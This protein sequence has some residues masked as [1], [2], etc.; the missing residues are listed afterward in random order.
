MLVIIVA[1]NLALSI[2]LTGVRCFHLAG[3]EKRN[4][5][6]NCRKIVCEITIGKIDNY[7]K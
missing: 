1:V 6:G 3:D 2:S 5:I 4:V 7:S